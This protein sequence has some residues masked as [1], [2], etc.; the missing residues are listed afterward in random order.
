LLQSAVELVED[1]LDLLAA[2]TSLASLSLSPF[3]PIVCALVYAIVLMEVE[4]MNESSRMDVV[5]AGMIQGKLK[6][7]GRIEESKT[8]GVR[9]LAIPPRKSAP[10]RSFIF[11]VPFPSFLFLHLRGLNGFDL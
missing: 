7:T 2:K 10:K 1:F 6:R 8:C 11:L 9:I 3:F 5:L 4:T